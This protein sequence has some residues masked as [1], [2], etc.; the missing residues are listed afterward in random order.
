MR[1]RIPLMDKFRRHP[2][3]P[4]PECEHDTRL[5][6]RYCQVCGY[7]IV[8]QTKADIARIKPL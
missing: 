8:Q 7:E 6:Q 2:T 5:D 1:I 4:C 3:G